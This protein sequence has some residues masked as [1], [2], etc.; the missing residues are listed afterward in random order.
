V[1]VGSS[2]LVEAEVIYQELLHLAL[3]PSHLHPL[4]L[5]KERQFLLTVLDTIPPRVD[6]ADLA[7][8]VE[9]L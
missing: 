8:L 2:I 5:L 1:V 7:I 4:Y 6:C 9:F 3:R